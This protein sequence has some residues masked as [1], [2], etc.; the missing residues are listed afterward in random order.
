MDLI[1]DEGYTLLLYIEKETGISVEP[2]EVGTPIP[3]DRHQRDV[4]Q[5]TGS[6]SPGCQSDFAEVFPPELMLEMDGPEQRPARRDH[7]LYL[8]RLQ[9]HR[10]PLTNVRIVAAPARL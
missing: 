3:G 10:R 1:D 6:S 9:P 8:D 4:R 7:H 2:L 5:S